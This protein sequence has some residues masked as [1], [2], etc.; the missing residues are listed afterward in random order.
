MA[1]PVLGPFISTPSEPF[2]DNYRARRTQAMPIDRPLDY[3]MYRNSGT[4]KFTNWFYDGSSSSPVPTKNASYSP[5]S[6]PGYAQALQST[7]N[8]A[9]EALRGSAG[10]T[11]GWA[12]NLAQMDKTRRMVVDRA[13][14]IANVVAAIRLGSFGAAAR[15]L[16]TPVPSSVSRRKA[17]AQN[18]L[19]FEYGVKPIISDLQ[20]AMVALTSTD[21]E[22]RSIRGRSRHHLQDVSSGSVGLSNYQTRTTTIRTCDIDITCRA[23]IRI[24]NPN[25]FLANQLGLLDLAL[26]WKLIPFSFVVDWFVNVEQVISATTAWYGCQLLHPHVSYFVTGNRDYYH[27][28]N[29]VQAS[30]ASQGYIQ[31]T[32]QESLTF[33]RVTGIPNPKL[34]MKPFKGFS[35]NR[36]AQALALVTAVLG[37]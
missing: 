21:F 23:I 1:L 33:E 3:R 7:Y 19:E 9:Y 12:E 11:G 25:L 36:G 32:R 13:V 22:D 15:A 14:Q 24:T 31:R 16:R 26:P 37:K 30:G 4:D 18:F 2:T 35:L 34:V 17:V 8:L 29:S 6:I 20:S 28:V 10:E 27:R 5:S